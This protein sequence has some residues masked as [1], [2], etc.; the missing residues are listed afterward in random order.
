[1]LAF[2]TSYWISI[3]MGM[4]C[5]T[6]ILGNPRSRLLGFFSVAISSSTDRL[7]E[8]FRGLG[9]C[10]IC[11]KLDDL[12]H[13]VSTSWSPRFLLW[14]F[15]FLRSLELGLSDL[16][17]S[18]PEIATRIICSLH[19]LTT[20]TLLLP[21]RAHSD[22]LRWRWRERYLT[23]QTIT[24]LCIQ[25]CGQELSSATFFPNLCQLKLSDENCYLG[26]SSGRKMP[27]DYLSHTLT[28]IHGLYIDGPE[29]LRCEWPA[30]AVFP[31]SSLNYCVKHQPLWNTARVWQLSRFLQSSQEFVIC[32]MCLALANSSFAEL[33][34]DLA[35]LSLAPEAHWNYTMER[36]QRACAVG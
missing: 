18:A 29:E 33:H 3:A 30:L 14:P 21:A 32:W 11:T 19:V 16:G 13:E 20:L 22:S 26:R 36:H 9:S 24:T 35:S 17:E 2:I 10:E 34:Q 1:M 25:G 4:V 27:G 6:P 8:D 5:P 31:T 23:F 7:L 15:K 28:D 12:S